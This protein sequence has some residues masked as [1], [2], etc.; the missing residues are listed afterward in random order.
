MWTLATLAIK[1]ATKI[2]HW[3]D[4]HSTD[5][6]GELLYF[7]GKSMVITYILKIVC[8]AFEHG[9]AFGGMWLLY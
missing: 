4:E 8:W 1:L 9:L 2:A 3:A 6:L 7:M 5:A